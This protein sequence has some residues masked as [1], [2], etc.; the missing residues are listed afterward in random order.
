MSLTGDLEHLPIVDVIQLMNSTR[1]SGILNVSG[2]K[3]ESQLVFKDGFIVSA[4]HLNNSVRIG[5]VLVGRG[6]ITEEALKQALEEQTKAGGGRAPLIVTLLEMGLVEEDQAYKGLQELIEMTII[7]ILTWKKGGFVLEA[8]LK[9]APDDYQYYPN[10]IKREINIDT[11]SV[12][13]DALRIFDEKMRDGE[14]SI[15]DENEEES[16]ITADDLGLSDLDHLE[17]KIPGVYAGLDDSSASHAGQGGAGP[18][19]LVRRLN[20]VIAGLADLGSAPEIALAQLR[21]AAEVFPRVLTLIVGRGELIAEK[22]IG[23]KSSDP[24]A[25][26][27]PLGLRIPLS[28]PSLL[29]RTVKSGDFYAGTCDDFVVEHLYT[30]LGAP[31]SGQMVLLPVKSAGRAVFLTYA[32]FGD[33][34]EG[35]IPEDLLEMLIDQ[36]GLALEKV[37]KRRESVR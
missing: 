37:L 16:E 13:M 20:D 19:N 33:E 23:I 9:Q 29:S 11:Q 24:A 5:E 35:D 10:D 8:N 1:K 17:R 27:S 7:E 28:E 15:E 21:F 14:L 32:D 34:P 22:S 30:R 36:T 18:D 26:S 31:S 6:A 2:R 25:V 12:L 3:G 4:S